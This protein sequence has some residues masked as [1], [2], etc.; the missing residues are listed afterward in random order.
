MRN[1]ISLEEFKSQSEEVQK[2]LIDTWEPQIGDLFTKGEEYS[3][4]IMGIDDEIQ[5]G[6]TMRS[7]GKSRFPLFNLQQLINVIEGKTGTKVQIIYNNSYTI[8]VGYIDDFK[9]ESWDAYEDVGQD[10]LEAIWK[11]ACKVVQEVNEIEANNAHS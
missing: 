8:D 10:L 11:V 7:K 1:F 2:A 9:I 6:I 3:R 4:K 5:V